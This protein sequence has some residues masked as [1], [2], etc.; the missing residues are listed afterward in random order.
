MSLP[1]NFLEGKTAIV[2]GAS[3]GIGKHVARALADSGMNLAIAARRVDRLEAV[4]TELIEQT[5]VRVIAIPT[6]V[7]DLAALQRLVSRTLDEF[8]QIDVLV[9]NAGV[10][11]YRHLHEL[12]P[13]T[14]KSV[15]DVNLTAAI[16][17]TQLVLPAMF[18]QGWGHI[19]NMASTAGKHSPPYGAVYGATKA[20][21]VA[22]TQSLRVEYRSRGISASAICPGFTEEGGIY[23]QL[24]TDLGRGAPR[25]IGSTTVEKVAR[26]T[27]R[28]IRHD[29]PEPIVN[30]PPMRPF[31]VLTAMFPRFGEWLLRKFAGHYFRR[32][33]RVRRELDQAPEPHRRAA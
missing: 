10:D 28:A 9:N 23:E 11:A 16:Q 31:L 14:V 18:E 19:I 3:S 1:R 24:K 2:T 4:R 5:G 17:L 33:G 20:G 7:A 13:E 26:A 15:V 8:G 29:Q 32:I 27:V 22:L 21:L 12:A 30:N 25:A 6:D